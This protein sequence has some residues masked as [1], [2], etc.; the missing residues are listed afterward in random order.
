[1]GVKIK[2]SSDIEAPRLPKYSVPYRRTDHDLKTLFR[3]AVR[4]LRQRKG[5]DQ[6]GALGFHG[7]QYL[8]D[9]TDHLLRQA[10]SFIETG[11]NVGT[12]SLHVARRNLDLKC[13]TCE[14]WEPAYKAA[15]EH[16][17]AYTNVRPYHMGSVEFLNILSGAWPPGPRV[18]WLDAHGWGFEWP[19]REELRRISTQPGADA[20]L[21]DDFKV[22]GLPEFG[23]DSYR[24]QTCS[25]EYIEPAIVEPPEAVYYPAYT[26]HTSRRHP[27]R[28]WILLVWGTQFDVE[29]CSTPLTRAR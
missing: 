28:G 18:W 22:P 15:A 17:A 27:L 6:L 19:L 2:R 9:L 20:V 21:V 24:G 7:D 10:R 26:E 25:W 5:V 8:I 1:M 3:S 13:L 11:T 16:L 4:A 14:P 29:G 23:F 12:T